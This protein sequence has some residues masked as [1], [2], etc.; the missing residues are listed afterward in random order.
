M[1]NVPAASHVAR[2]RGCAGEA[3]SGSAVDYEM[4]AAEMAPT[5]TATSV[6]APGAASAA[7][8]TATT[9]AATA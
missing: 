5:Q 1:G 4:T 2:V 9:V 8:P 7:M 3:A 6:P